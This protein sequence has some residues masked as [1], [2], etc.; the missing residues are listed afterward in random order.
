VDRGGAAAVPVAT[1]PFTREVDR[2]TATGSSS[3]C[4]PSGAPG[5]VESGADTEEYL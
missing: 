4:E 5:S 3:S 2:A 1:Y